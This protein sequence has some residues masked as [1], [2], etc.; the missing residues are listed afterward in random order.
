[1]AQLFAGNT[2]LI[3]NSTTIALMF[4][5]LNASTGVPS[6][7]AVNWSGFPLAV[8]RLNPT[9]SKKNGSSRG[10]A[11]T[12]ISP[13]VIT[14]AGLGFGPEVPWVASPSITTWLGKTARKVWHAAA[15]AGHAGPFP[16]GPNTK[17]ICAVGCASARVVK[18]SR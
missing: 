12:L 6:E 13:A 16:N 3:G 15:G 14:F 8:A 10:P 7:K 9:R 5:P 4:L 17:S 11:N 18:F 1:E 2:M